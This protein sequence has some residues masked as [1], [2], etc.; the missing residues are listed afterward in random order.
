MTDGSFELR[1]YPELSIATTKDGG[2]GDQAFMRLFR[3]IEGGNEAKQKIAMTTPVFMDGSAGGKEMS[4]VLPKDV[5][6]APA[7]KEP[8]VKVTKR[9]AAKYAVYRFSG[10]RSAKSEAGA[11][12]KLREWMKAKGMKETG[13]LTFAYYDPPW[14]PGPM[15]RNE[16]LIRIADDVKK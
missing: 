5:A 3:Y 2:D 4:F 1:E 9:A 10:G 7:A 6:V 13:S 16:A 15:R 14:T 11:A 12:A 8:E